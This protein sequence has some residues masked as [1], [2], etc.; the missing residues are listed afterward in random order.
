MLNHLLIT[1]VPRLRKPCISSNLLTPLQGRLTGVKLGQ[2]IHREHDFHIFGARGDRVQMGF[3]SNRTMLFWLFLKPFFTNYGGASYTCYWSFLPIFFSNFGGASDTRV[4]PIHR[5]I[6]YFHSLTFSHQSRQFCV[7]TT[8]T[9]SYRC[10]VAGESAPRCIIP[11]QLKNEKT[12]K[13][14]TCIIYP[15]PHNDAKI[16]QLSH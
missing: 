14:C 8:L 10:G 7:V 13:V 5:C 12:G 4:R 3:V 2:Q 9:F 6:W 1:H 15:F 16:N 11:S